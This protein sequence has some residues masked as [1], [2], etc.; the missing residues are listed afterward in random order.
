M[1]D[2]NQT[3]QGIFA[4]KNA[5]RNP[6]QIMQMLIQKNPQ[7]QQMLT[8]LQNMAGGR[9]PKEFLTQ[10]AKQNGVSEQNISAIEQIL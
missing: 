4:M 8:T 3:L 7:V 10:I 1:N 2:I 6:Q 9:S 5:G